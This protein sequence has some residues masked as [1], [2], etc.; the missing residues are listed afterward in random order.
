MIVDGSVLMAILP[1][2]PEAN[3]IDTVLANCSEPLMS[4]GS[5]LET[6]MDSLGQRGADGLKDLDSLIARL[7]I[8]VVPFTES[9]ALIARRAFE[10]F[11]KGRHRA[12]LN[13]GGCIAYAL[14]KETGEELLFKDTDFGQTDV[15]VA[16]Y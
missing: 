13:F 15:A 5:F 10:R 7:G 12:Q 3:R 2:E 9:Q 8:R 11:G 1:Q 4:A 6:S 16:A 14:A